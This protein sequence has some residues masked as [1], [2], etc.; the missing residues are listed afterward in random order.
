MAFLQILRR[1]FYVTFIRIG[2]PLYLI[3]T[4]MEHSSH[5]C[6]K[7]WVVCI[8]APIGIIMDCSIMLLFT[9]KLHQQQRFLHFLYYSYILFY[10]PFILLERAKTA[11]FSQYKLFRHLNKEAKQFIA[12][13]NRRIREMRENDLIPLIPTALRLRLEASREQQVRIVTPE[14]KALLA[15]LVSAVVEARRLKS[16]L[17]KAQSFEIQDTFLELVQAGKSEQAEELIRLYERGKDLEESCRA[18]GV[19]LVKN[20]P[21]NSAYLEQLEKLIQDKKQELEREKELAALRELILD[22]S[23]NLRPEFNKRLK[24][25]RAIQNEREF[26]MA[27]YSLRQDLVQVK[28]AIEAAKKKASCSP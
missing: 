12:A 26:R 27:V 11:H 9:S 1:L 22:I 6:G 20:Q 4:I 24:A 7:L 18:L 3:L 10:H 16:Y 5:N 14:Q 8:M 23:N 19:K 28:K 21:Y 15:D 13:F 25:A 2:M 17:V